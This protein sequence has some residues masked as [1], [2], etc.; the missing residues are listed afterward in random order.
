M[1]WQLSLVAIACPTLIACSTT[2]IEPEIP[3]RGITPGYL[4][5]A[6]GL[7]T[8]VGSQANGKVGADALNKSGARRLRWI[9]PNTA[10]TK[11]YRQDRLNISYDDNMV[12]T[13]VN[14]G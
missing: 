9:A 12:I 5:K 10:V 7:E 1:K 2:D 11:D 6:N 3:E 14:C 8:L 13:R 4:C